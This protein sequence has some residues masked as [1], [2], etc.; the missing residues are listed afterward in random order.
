MKTEHFKKKLEEE[1][2]MIESEL[3]SVGRRN[4]DDPNDWEP[5]NEVPT[6]ALAEMEERAGEIM[7]FSDNAALEASLESRLAKIRTA[8]T[9][10]DDGTY[11]I[12]T[13]CGAAIEEARLEASPSAT[14]CI[15]HRDTE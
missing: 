11:G 15:A 9:R 2:L 5:A 8:L 3:A 14:T 1:R 10:I 6:E 12:C 4:P 7:E 13:V